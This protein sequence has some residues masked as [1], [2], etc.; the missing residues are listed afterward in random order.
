MDLFS[1]NADVSELILRKNYSRAAK[2]LRARLEKEPNKSSLR[3]QLADVLILDGRR[4]EA[5]PLLESLADEYAQEGFVAKAIAVLKKIQ[6]LDPAK[7]SVDEKL[8][9]LFKEKDEHTS[10]VTAM[11]RTGQIPIRTSAPPSAPEFPQKSETPTGDFII[12]MGGQ[13]MVIGPEPPRAIPRPLEPPRAFPVPPAIPGWMPPSLSPTESSAEFATPTGA[14]D[15]EILDLDVSEPA[16]ASA[17]ASS[18]VGSGIAKTPL[19]SDFNTEELV[20]VI[21]GLQLHTY[22]PGDIIVSEGEAGTSL[23]VISTGAVKA[24]VRDASG[25]AHPIRLMQEGDFFGEMALLTGRPRT[26]TITAATAC[27]LLELHSDN[28]RQIVGS[29]PRVNNVLRA[30]CEIRMRNPAETLIRRKGA[31]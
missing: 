19:F 4:A 21:K 8:A 1:L 6:R 23:Y 24:F 12:E 3:Q 16:A 28:V 7:V 22:E 20:A 30:F 26:A 14:S 11:R 27:E 17:A 29:Y 10:K 25:R 5:L 2:V 18:T 9:R 31:E 13:E 15:S